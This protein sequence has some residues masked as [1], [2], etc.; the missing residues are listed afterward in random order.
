MRENILRILAEFYRENPIPTA[1]VGGQLLVYINGRG[2]VEDTLVEDLLMHRCESVAKLSQFTKAR[3]VRFCVPVARDGSTSSVYWEWVSEDTLW[4]GEWRPLDIAPH[5]LVFENCLVDLKTHEVT[6]RDQFTRPIYGP[7]ITAPYNP[8]A[9][10][11]D[12][13]DTVDLFFPDPDLR[14]Y[15]QQLLST[16]L[17]PHHMIKGAIVF[18]GGSNTGKSTVAAACAAAPGGPG[19]HTT[20]NPTRAAQSAFH[21]SALMNKFAALCEELESVSKEGISWLK[22]YTGGVYE[23]EIKFGARGNSVPTAK[24]LIASNSLP[25]LPEDSRALYHRLAI[26]PMDAEVPLARVDSDRSNTLYWSRPDRRVGVLAWMIQG[27][28]ALVRNGMRLVPPE[29]VTKIRSEVH[30]ETHPVRRNLLEL[31]ELASG[32]DEARVSSL[33]LLQELRSTTRCNITLRRLVKIVDEVFPGVVRD[34]YCKRVGGK[35]KEGAGFR[36]LRRR[37]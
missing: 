9:M 11:E 24:L 12:W 19:G 5:Q 26:L 3:S 13:L 22:S 25:D 15:A 17:I 33:A 14:S 32:D 37:E 23:W 21:S 6:P 10:C 30:V 27:L 35:W 29:A 31:Y 8:E 16:L 2:W 34:R 18:L 4:D 20:I 36:Y 7:V 1:C 28:N